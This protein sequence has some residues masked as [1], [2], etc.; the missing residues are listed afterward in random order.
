MP[1][2]ITGIVVGVILIAAFI[3]VRKKGMSCNE[4]KTCKSC[5][6]TESCIKYK[7]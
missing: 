4:C 6:Q 3:Y 5:P 7:K 2:V 1:T